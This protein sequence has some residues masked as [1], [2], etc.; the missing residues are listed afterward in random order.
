MPGWLKPITERKRNSASMTLHGNMR[1]AIQDV[2]CG[3]ITF[4]ITIFRMVAER[5]VHQAERLH[6]RL[7]K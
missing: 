6:G 5:S 7:H 1:T 3:T 4:G 2:L